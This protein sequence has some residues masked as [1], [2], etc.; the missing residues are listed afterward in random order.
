MYPAK[1]TISSIPSFIIDA[2]RTIKKNTVQ[3]TGSIGEIGV[4]EIIVTAKKKAFAGRL[5]CLPKT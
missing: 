3:L 1:L 5:N 2:K 4:K